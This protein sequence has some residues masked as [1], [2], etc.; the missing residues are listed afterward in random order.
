MNHLIKSIYKD[1]LIKKRIPHQYLYQRLKGRLTGLWEISFRHP[2][3][4]NLLYLSTDPDEITMY[5]S[6]KYYGANEI[7]ISICGLQKSRKEVC[8]ETVKWCIRY[9]WESVKDFVKKLF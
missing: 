1:V 7:I 9:V 5:L 8:K 3:N 4:T 6:G 2:G